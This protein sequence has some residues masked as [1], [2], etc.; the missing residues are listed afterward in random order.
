MATTWIDY[1]NGTVS[2]AAMAA[3]GIE[4][5][6]R[7]VGIG[8]AG[9]RLT[10][11]EYADHV[12]HGRQTAVVVERNTT[13]AD[14]GLAAGRANAQLALADLRAI[15][16]GL[17]PI[18]FLFAAN[19]KSAFTRADVD[20]VRGFQDVLLPA[21]IT[22]GPYG[23]G[24]FVAACRAARL[25]PIAWQTG[26]APSRTNTSDVATL[27]Q[28]NGTA[29]KAAD[30]PATPT[31]RVLAGVTCDLSNRLLAFKEVP[32]TSPIDKLTERDVQTI[33]QASK[34][35]LVG[36]QLAGGNPAGALTTTLFAVKGEIAN[37][38]A[39]VKA[40]IAAAVSG[41]QTGTVDPKAFATAVAPLIS[42]ADLAEFKAQFEK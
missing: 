4:G 35:W 36:N 19:D 31:T 2:G 32:V 13:D 9:K 29:G 5:A 40:T 20:Y 23:F 41:L 1:S 17:P 27:W 25:T 11:A 7:Y 21:R 39:D 22:V 12:A 8:G 15:T 30:G 38:D 28:R 18:R 42:Q 10:R 34:N 3:A 14:G 6:I 37:A 16:S 26:P 24:S 33:L